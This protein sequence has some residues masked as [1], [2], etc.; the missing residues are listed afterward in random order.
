MCLFAGGYVQSSLDKT[1]R[2]LAERIARPHKPRAYK[3][4]YAGIIE[5][6]NGA[7]IACETKHGGKK[8]SAKRHHTEAQPRLVP[9]KDAFIP[10]AHAEIKRYFKGI[11][12]P[13]LQ[14]DNKQYSCQYDGEDVI[15]SSKDAV[16]HTNVV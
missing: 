8:H 3:I 5:R 7:Q 2:E 9:A 6:N 4:R 13:F 16:S 11:E 1:I 10:D 15:E 12:P 14:H